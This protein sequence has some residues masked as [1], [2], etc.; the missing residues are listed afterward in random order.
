MRLRGA[1]P[2]A[3]SSRGG[4]GS[5]V[6]FIVLEYGGEQLLSLT[7]VR[8]EADGVGPPA[9]HHV[10]ACCGGAGQPLKRGVAGRKAHAD[11]ALAA[12]LRC[13]A[14]GVMTREGRGLHK[15]GCVITREHTKGGA[16]ITRDG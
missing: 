11:V 12:L 15:G 8:V 5:T 14:R 7:V 10:Q 13:V 16:W 4:S 6:L 9:R 3:E 1:L 2:G